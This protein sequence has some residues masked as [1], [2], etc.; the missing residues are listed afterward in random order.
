MLE[1]SNAVNVVFLNGSR[2]PYELDLKMVKQRKVE[3]SLIAVTPVHV[4][5]TDS[6]PAEMAFV[7]TTYKFKLQNIILTGNLQF[8]CSSGSS[9]VLTLIEINMSTQPSIISVHKCVNLELYIS[10]CTFDGTYME[11]NAEEST[12]SFKNI[13]MINTINTNEA[14]IMEMVPT[15]VFVNLDYNDGSHSI[16]VE[17]SNFTGLGTPVTSATRARPVAA[18]ALDTLGSL[19]EVRILITNSTFM[20]N[21]RALDIAMKGQNSIQVSG[22][23]FINNVGDGAGGAIRISSHMDPGVGESTNVRN[24]DI[25]IWDSYFESNFAETSES[26]K[27]DD[28]YY[29]V[30]A[31]GSGG[32][33]YVYVTPRSPLKAD[34]YVEIQGCTFTNNSASTSGG[35]LFLCPV[36]LTSIRNTQIE[37]AKTTDMTQARMGDAIFASG[38]MVIDNLDVSINTVEEASPLIYYQAADLLNDKLTVQALAMSC[39]QGFRINQ[40]NTSFANGLQS[41]QLYC[42]SCVSDE[43]SLDTTSITIEHTLGNGNMSIGCHSCPYGAECDNGIINMD[44]FWG[45]MNDNGSEVN[46]YLCP[47]DYCTRN[48][49]LHIQY[50]HCE[51]N[52]IGTLCGRCAEGYSEALYGT[53]CV[54]DEECSITKPASIGLLL[55]YLSRGIIFVVMLLFASECKEIINLGIAKVTPH[56]KA[57]DVHDVVNH[58]FLVIYFYFVQTVELLQVNIVIVP[59]DTTSILRP[60]DVLPEIFLEGVNVGDEIQAASCFFPGIKPVEKLALTFVYPAYV[61]TLLVLVYLCTGLCCMCRKKADRPRIAQTGPARLVLVLLALFLFLYQ[62][63]AESLLQLLHCVNV[64]NKSVL[65]IDGNV[66]CLQSWQFAV[67]AITCIF[68]FPFFV[69]LLF[70]PKVLKERKI[71]LGFFFFALV[72]PMFCFIPIIMV[73]WGFIDVIP[74]LSLTKQTGM[75]SDKDIEQLVAP[76]NV[77]CTP[78]EQ[79]DHS[80]SKKSKRGMADDTLSGA[81][82]HIDSLRET[83]ADSLAGTYRSWED[84]GDDFIGGVCWEGVL[85][86]QRLVLVV[87]HTFTPEVVLRQIL[88]CFLVFIILICQTKQMPFQR[89]TSNRAQIGSICIILMIGMVNLIRATFFHSGISPRDTVYVLVIFFE[90]IEIIC[91]K[92][93]PWLCI[94]VALIVVCAKGVN[95]KVRATWSDQE[96]APHVAE[97]ECNESDDG[98]THGFSDGEEDACNVISSASNDLEERPDLTVDDIEYID[99]IECF[100]FESSTRQQEKYLSD[101]RSSDKTESETQLGMAPMTT[102][103]DMG[104]NSH[105][106]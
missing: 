84:D 51:D 14:Q 75:L 83:V 105:L 64:G 45:D 70:G 21:Q 68:I 17:N 93:L 80:K 28:T 97:N 44:N 47:D 29:K 104:F 48:N 60:A 12:S 33:I 87:V 88:L 9:L 2:R 20:D 71:T 32:A 16:T 98:L 53:A 7:N 77:L 40:I 102:W 31:P 3:L 73:F 89:K 79:T 49:S 36:I 85:N 72:F 74:P 91:T 95:D 25:Y 39:A 15:G 76:G 6:G 43:Y 18:F 38:N 78:I 55:L 62:G 96:L 22:C 67:I 69:I 52:R 1:N 92:F 42:T 26:Y 10:G 35:T 100:H 24:P 13:N 34:G 86:L 50:N 94:L 57:D 11:F 103:T 41:L 63:I 37:N 81:G 54:P 8:S 30:W 23:T 4:V 99:A 59:D 106:D 27:D 46:M 5:V 56:G 58:G 90:W 66:E 65:F 19:S 82:D 61:F 101:R